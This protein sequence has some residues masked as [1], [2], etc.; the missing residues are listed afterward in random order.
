MCCHRDAF[1]ARAELQAYHLDLP[2]LLDLGTCG[3]LPP[4]LS[5]LLSSAFVIESSMAAATRSPSPGATLA[6]PP[7]EERDA[8]GVSVLTA[9]NL[10]RSQRSFDAAAPPLAQSTLASLLW[11]AQGVTQPPAGASERP[12]GRTCPSAGGLFPLEVFLING[13]DS[14]QA[15]TRMLC[16]CPPTR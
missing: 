8:G 16:H 5:A 11:A 10:R 15:R 4:Y 13:A 7:P 14:I 9:L 1:R 12:K 6:L 2:R 3:T